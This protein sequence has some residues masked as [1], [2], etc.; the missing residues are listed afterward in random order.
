MWSKKDRKKVLSAFWNLLSAG[1]LFFLNIFTGN[2]FAG[3]H[4]VP[5]TKNY[6][7]NDPFFNVLRL[8]EYVSQFQTHYIFGYC[9]EKL[10]Q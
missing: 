8:G 6:C 1:N 7:K 3:K 4:V 5:D 2:V 10:H 9:S